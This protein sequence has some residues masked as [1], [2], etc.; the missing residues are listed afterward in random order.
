MISIIID[1]N[2]DID[3]FYSADTTRSIIETKLTNMEWKCGS[4][5]ISSCQIHDYLFGLSIFFNVCLKMLYILGN[6]T[7]KSLVIIIL[8]CR[9]HTN[10]EITR[11]S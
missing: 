6:Y 2:N 1:Y 7:D 8:K 4:G 3:T 5:F 11:K 9:T 10:M